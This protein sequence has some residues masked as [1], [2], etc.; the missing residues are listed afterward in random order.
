MEKKSL[1]PEAITQ[2]TVTALEHLL[3]VQA[4]AWLEEEPDEEMLQ[5]ASEAA[6]NETAENRFDRFT[7]AHEVAAEGIRQ[8]MKTREYAYL[9][10]AGGC[11]M[12][13]NRTP[14][15]RELIEDFEYLCDL[16]TGLGQEAEFYKPDNS[17]N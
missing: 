11:G 2:Q 8:I 17:E 3:G 10:S 14:R 4:N 5:E 7:K 1:T 13:A 9:I 12:E 15:G 16:R 6:N